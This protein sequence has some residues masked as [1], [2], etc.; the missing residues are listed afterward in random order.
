MHIDKRLKKFLSPAEAAAANRC[1]HE[2]G[3]HDETSAS[4]LSGC[5]IVR[6]QRF[7]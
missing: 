1:D 5:S 6:V 3:S 4:L 7:T 2:A